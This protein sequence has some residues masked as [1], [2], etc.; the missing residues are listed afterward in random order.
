MS[1][2]V[3][4]RLIPGGRRESRRFPQHLPANIQ[5]NIH[6]VLLFL[7][8]D[9]D[10]YRHFIEKNTSV[11]AKRRKQLTRFAA[12]STSCGGRTRRSGSPSRFGDLTICPGYF[13]PASR[14][15]VTVFQIMSTTM[16]QPSADESVFHQSS[17][18]HDY[19]RHH[20]CPRHRRRAFHHPCLQAPLIDWR[21]QDE[22]RTPPDAAVLALNRHRPDT[23]G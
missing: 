2:A 14:V 21:V 16:T 5:R 13:V 15:K 1:K 20:Y 19:L 10:E 22:D 12:L 3:I 6:K 8:A 11:S 18:M 17:P 4:D 7:A 23:P 9:F